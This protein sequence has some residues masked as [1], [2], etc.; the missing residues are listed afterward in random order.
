M[1]IDIYSPCPGGTGKKI[2]FC[3]PDFV[4]ELDKINRMIEG[5]QFQGCLDLVRRLLKTSPQRACLMASECLL[6]RVTDHLEEAQDAARQFLAAH[7]ENPLAWS[8]TAIVTAVTE[9]G[10]PAMK[11]LQKALARLGREISG[12]AYE[13]LWTVGQILAIEGDCLAA[14]AVLCFRP[15][16]CGR[17][18]SGPSADGTS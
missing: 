3:C 7:P 12:R 15:T 5:E 6:L 18:P 8:E 9:G 11:P 1:A 17:R 10:R 14:E 2:K 4:G 16:Q 13:M